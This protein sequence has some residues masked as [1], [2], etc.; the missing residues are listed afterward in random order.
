M[1]TCVDFLGCASCV[2][3]CFRWGVGSGSR[4]VGFDLPVFPRV[5]IA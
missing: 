4:V 3:G 5:I 2:C 1:S